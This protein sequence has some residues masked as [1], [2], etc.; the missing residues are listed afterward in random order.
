MKFLMLPILA[1]II[2][3]IFNAILFYTSGPIGNRPLRILRMESKDG[4][5]WF[6]IQQRDWIR[7]WRSCTRMVGMDTY[8]YIDFDNEEDAESW[9]QAQLDYR[10]NLEGSKICKQEEIRRYK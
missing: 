6:R 10:K 5:V 3:L 2:F 1:L 4:K 8:A 9:I 7:I